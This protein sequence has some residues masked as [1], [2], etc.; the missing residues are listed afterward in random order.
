MAHG[1]PPYCITFGPITFLRVGVIW[2]LDIG[3]IGIFGIDGHM[4]RFRII[5]P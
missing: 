1:K 5:N 4:I 3:R 2:S